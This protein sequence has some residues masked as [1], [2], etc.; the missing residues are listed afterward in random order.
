MDVSLTVGG[1]ANLTLMSSAGSLY[2][3]V[4]QISQR[5]SATHELLRFAKLLSGIFEP[6]FGVLR[7]NVGALSIA[8]WKARD[9]LPIS[10]K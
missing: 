10:D 7:E 3:Q 6:P 9:G 1:L 8:R 5:E 4:A 2:Q